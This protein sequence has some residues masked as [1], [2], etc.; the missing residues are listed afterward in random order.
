MNTESPPADMSFLEHVEELRWRIIKSLL[1]V[2]IGATI[3]YLFVNQIID[4]LIAPTRKLDTGMDLQVL[5]VQ[6]M[7]MVK[8]GL[9]FLGGVVLA[10]PVLT[11]QIWKF[12]APGLYENERSYAMPLVIFTFVSFISGIV[13]AYMVLIPFS[14]NFFASMGYGDI[15]NNISINY[16]FSFM[17]WLLIGTGII[18]ELPVLTFL[19]AVIGLVTAA[20]M[21]KYRRHAVIIIMVLSA[22]ITP[23]DPVSLFVMT[24]PLII[25][26]EISIGV[27]WISNRRHDRK[28]AGDSVS[29]SE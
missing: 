16:Y 6:G 24:A 23:P 29:T 26:Y 15:A 27:A 10:I 17:A 5:K 7:F 14:L 12:V 11:Y 2:A 22:F 13:F 4:L 28:L 1:A 25:L 18:F 21:R 3:T 20:G 9:A 19:L 8:W